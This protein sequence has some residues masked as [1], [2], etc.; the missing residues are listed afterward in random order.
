MGRL[1]SCDHNTFFFFKFRLLKKVKCYSIFCDIQLN[2]HN[3]VCMVFVIQYSLIKQ[4]NQNLI[5]NN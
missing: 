1:V 3:K 2:R 4:V 5:Q